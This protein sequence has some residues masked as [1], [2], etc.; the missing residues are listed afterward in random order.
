MKLT[1]VRLLVLVNI[2]G[3]PILGVIILQHNGG[4]NDRLTPAP[5]SGCRNATF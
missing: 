5:E 2:R 4:F 3:A 1:S